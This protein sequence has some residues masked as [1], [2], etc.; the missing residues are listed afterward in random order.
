MALT[1]T[2]W[3]REMQRK[4]ES[5]MELK[6]HGDTNHECDSYLS[7]PPPYRSRQTRTHTNTK[8]F[9]KQSITS[10]GHHGD[11]PAAQK[12]S[13]SAAEISCMSSWAGPINSHR[14]RR[15]SWTR[16]FPKDKR[17]INK[18]QCGKRNTPFLP[19]I[20]LC[21]HYTVCMCVS[22]FVLEM[23]TNPK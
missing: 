12:A 1:H 9:K 4:R 21:P 7:V 3:F 17:Y 19:V 14:G 20:L 18:Q 6:Q 13:N 11:Y 23:E 5:K 8:I 2:H 10:K 15:W 22:D 16:C